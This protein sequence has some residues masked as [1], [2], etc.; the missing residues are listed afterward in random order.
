MEEQGADVGVIR[1]K[2]K[3]LDY[4]IQVALKICGTKGKNAFEDKGMPNMLES[5]D[6]FIINRIH[7]LHHKPFLTRERFYRF[8]AMI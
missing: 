4:G 8:I 5:Y 6:L 7:I 2:K 1:Q 3:L